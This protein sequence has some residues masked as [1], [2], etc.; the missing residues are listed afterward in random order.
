MFNTSRVFLFTKGLNFTKQCTDTSRVTQEGC[1]NLYCLG[2]AE[3]K[4]L[5]FSGDPDSW[6]AK[7]VNSSAED[8][9]FVICRGE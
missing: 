5:F 6:N 7:V 8:V 4:M 2:T 1:S 3:K 9:E